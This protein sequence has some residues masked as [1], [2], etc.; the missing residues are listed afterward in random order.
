[1]ARNIPVGNGELLVTFDD[2]YRVR[3]IYYPRVGMPNHT[4]GQPQR[5]GVW[6]DGQFAWASDPAWH[7]S[8]KYKPDTMITQ[9]T[10]RHEGLGLELTCNDAVDYWSPVYFRKVV[11]TDLHN[12]HRDV[13]VFFHHDFSLSGSPVGDTVNYDP[14]LSGL[15]HYKDETYFLANGSDQRKSGIDHWATGSKRI[16]GAEGT[17]R[18]AEDGALSHNAI[19][20]GSVDSTI[21]FNVHVQPRGSS[22]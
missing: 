11:V 14:S 1:M 22:T 5:F 13:R 16:G 2:L 8:L 3:D 9:V 17:W 20:Q 10:L 15:V 4:D 19:A 21:G 7:R 12:R 6:A 18:D